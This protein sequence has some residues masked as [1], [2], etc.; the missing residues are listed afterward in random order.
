M[1]RLSLQFS[2]YI[3]SSFFTTSLLAT[4]TNLNEDFEILKDSGIN[5]VQVGTIC[6]EVAKLRLEKIYPADEYEVV[7][8]I[9]YFQGSRTVGELDVIVFR[10]SDQ[11]AVVVAEVKCW[12][13]LSAGLKKAKNQMNRFKEFV[14][15]NKIDRMSKDGQSYSAK[16]FDENP[17]FI[18][19]SQTGG[20]EKGFTMDIDL[21]LAESQSLRSKIMKCQ[22]QGDCAKPE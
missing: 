9:S 16:Q 21:T 15:S 10:N 8:G 22:N 1:K 5:Y 2:A 20:V 19:I 18:T 6:E 11:E 3:L 7:T 12:K 13:R 14:R 4:P 17:E